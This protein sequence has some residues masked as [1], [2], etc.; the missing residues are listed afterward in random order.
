VLAELG[1]TRGHGVESGSARRS[2]VDSFDSLKSRNFFASAL[3]QRSQPEV[4][5]LED[6][7]SK[8]EEVEDKRDLTKEAGLVRR[9][10]AV[11]TNQNGSQY[12]WMLADTYAGE[13]FY[14]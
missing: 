4:E 3:R 13:T 2:L 5:S 1:L 6:L 14:E 10:N 12:I 7:A 9:D 8:A 11:E